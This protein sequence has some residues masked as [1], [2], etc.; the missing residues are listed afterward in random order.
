VE[1]LDSIIDKALAERS[2][3]VKPKENNHKVS[4]SLR[5]ALYRRLQKRGI[6]RISLFLQEHTVLLLDNTPPELKV[7]SQ[8][9]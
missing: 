7:E 5:Y 9:T 4:S 8:A 1:E 6:T 3:M 2:A